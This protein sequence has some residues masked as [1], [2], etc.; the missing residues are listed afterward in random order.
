MT[1]AEVSIQRKT[2]N[3]AT[4]AMNTGLRPKRSASRP[5]KAAPITRPTLLIVKIHFN[6]A[7][8]EPELGS[9]LRRGDTDRLNI[10]SFDHR[11]GKSTTQ[12]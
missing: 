12:S 5:P 3:A 10:E 4:D 1:L 6:F 2:P 8:G 7:R 11:N 9:K